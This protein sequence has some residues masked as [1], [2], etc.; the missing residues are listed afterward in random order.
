MS[1]N[2]IFEG[3]TEELADLLDLEPGRL[4][5]LRDLLT[6]GDLVGLESQEGLEPQA[7]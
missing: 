7:A 4:E 5:V 6:L 2:V 3:T 1:E